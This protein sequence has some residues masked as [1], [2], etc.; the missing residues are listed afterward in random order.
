M[1]LTA[2]TTGVPSNLNVDWTWESTGGDGRA[3][4]GKQQRSHSAR[5]TAWTR[6]SNVTVTMNLT[7]GD[8]DECLASATVP[9][10]IYA[11]ASIGAG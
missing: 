1:G 5:W 4:H 3:G 9:V 11:P 8:I 10:G 2:N 6:L 7:G